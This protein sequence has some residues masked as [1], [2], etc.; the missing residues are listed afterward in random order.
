[1]GD[2]S[3]AGES[4]HRTGLA[5][6]YGAEFAQADVPE[7][8][9]VVVGAGVELAI[10]H[11]AGT[12][13]GPKGEEYHIT[14]AAAGAVLPLCQSAGVGVILQ[15]C[16][17]ACSLLHQLHDRDI[18]PTGQVR[19]RH[20]HPRLAVQRAAAGYA[21]AFGI[22]FVQTMLRTDALQLFKDGGDGALHVGGIEAHLVRDFNDAIGVDAVYHRALRA[23]YVYA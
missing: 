9:G 13:A 21:Y 3:P 14:G 6:A 12:E 7:F 17:D 11:E 2:A 15:A 20:H 1:M 18:V 10:Q 16:R 22:A 8:T 4:F 19:R 5:V 23:A